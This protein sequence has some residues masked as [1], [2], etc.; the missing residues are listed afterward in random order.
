MTKNIFSRQ[1][2]LSD[3]AILIYLALFKLLIHVFT[4]MAGGYG[5]FRDEFYY[6]ACS[7]HLDLGYVDQPPLSIF[8]LAISRW[9]LGDSLVALR[10]LPAVAGA[11][12]VFLT[13]LMVRE[14]GGGRFAQSLAAL[15][16]I[17]APTYLGLNNS[18][19]DEQL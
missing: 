7:E 6:I 8:I 15:A 5:Y 19:F 2:L 10:F 17:V 14:L 13:G 4:N 9:I 18:F 1:F 16:V 3:I 12:M 11:L